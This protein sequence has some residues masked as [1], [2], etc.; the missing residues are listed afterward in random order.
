MDVYPSKR[1]LVGRVSP[2]YITIITIITRIIIVI[3]VITRI[4]VVIVII[5][6]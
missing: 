4:F 2:L 5:I 1:L 6:N 3:P